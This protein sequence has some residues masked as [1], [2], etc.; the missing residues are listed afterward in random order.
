[1]EVLRLY[2]IGSAW[3]SH[4]QDKKGSIEVGKFADLAVLSDNYFSIPD[5]EIKGL[6]SVLTIVGGK[7]VY[8]RDEFKHLNPPPLPV[9]PDWSPVK[10]YDG[11]CRSYSQSSIPLNA[12]TDSHFAYQHIHK[13]VYGMSGLWRLGCDCF[14]F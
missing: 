12:Y 14:A 1:M 5:E 13:L 10:K 7:V 8:G 11:Y 9:S 3:F 4:E 2:T 6:E